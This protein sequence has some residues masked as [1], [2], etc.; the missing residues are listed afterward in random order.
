[1]VA[2]VAAAAPKGRIIL[3]GTMGGGTAEVSL[4]LVMRKRLMIR[5][6]MLRSRSIAEKIEATENFGREVLPLLAAR[7]IQPVVDCVM[8]LEKAADAHRLMESNQT[9]GKIVLSI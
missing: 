2:S 8:P 4:G 7:T 1:M 9:V 3:V 5:G 6:T